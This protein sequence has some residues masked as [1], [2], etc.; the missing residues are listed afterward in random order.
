M[1]NDSTE[2]EILH[3]FLKLFITFKIALRQETLWKWPESKLSIADILHSRH[4]VIAGTFSWNHLNHSQILIEKPQ[5]CGHFYSRQLL[6]LS[7]VSC[8]NRRKPTSVESMGN[9][10]YGCTNFASQ[11]FPSLWRWNK[12][13]I[14]R[15]KLKFSLS[16]WVIRGW[17][18]FNVHNEGRELIIL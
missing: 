6:Q 16:D 13:L 17:G 7:T 1:V 2:G 10:F 18:Y 14:K 3:G 11:I 8:S 12:V 9:L 4:L 5:Y 15:Y